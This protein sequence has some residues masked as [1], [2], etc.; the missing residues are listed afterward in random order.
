M[1]D[2]TPEW[3]VVQLGTVFGYGPTREAAIAEARNWVDCELAETLTLDTVPELVGRCSTADRI[4][5]KWMT[6]RGEFTDSELT[7]MHGDDAKALGIDLPEG[8]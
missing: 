5:R 4:G 7:L 6:N 2:Q 1:T 3:L 8:L